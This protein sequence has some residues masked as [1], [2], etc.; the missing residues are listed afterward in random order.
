MCNYKGEIVICQAKD[1]KTALEVKPQQETIWLT[2][3]QM[4][5]LFNKDM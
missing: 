4:S 2:Q 5:K 3:V 1:G